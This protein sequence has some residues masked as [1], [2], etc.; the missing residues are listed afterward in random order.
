MHC[1]DINMKC[2]SCWTPDHKVS[3]TRKIEQQ[4]IG[5]PVPFDGGGGG[6]AGSRRGLPPRVTLPEKLVCTPQSSGPVPSALSLRTD[7]R[8]EARILFSRVVSLVIK[9]V[10]GVSFLK[11]LRSAKP[12]PSLDGQAGNQAST[13]L[14][15]RGWSLNQEVLAET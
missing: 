11:E 4:K 10:S 12:I 14:G 6:G 9:S 3:R 15:E 8:L 5:L 2:Y 7:G 13:M 1:F